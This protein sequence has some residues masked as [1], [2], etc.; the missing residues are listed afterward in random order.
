VTALRFL[1]RVMLRKAHVVVRLP[2]IRDPRKLPLVLS[3]E[4]VA[5]LLD[6]APGLKYKTALSVAYSAGLRVRDHLA[7]SR[8]HRQHSDGDPGRAG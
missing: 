4:E 2:F 7:Q 3:P 8:G 5:R 6:A 1:F